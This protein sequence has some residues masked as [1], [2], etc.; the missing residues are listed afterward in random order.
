MSKHHPSDTIAKAKNGRW[1]GMSWSELEDVRRSLR[2]NKGIHTGLGFVGSS[3]EPTKKAF[4]FLGDQNGTVLEIRK[5]ST[6]Y[7]LRPRGRL[8]TSFN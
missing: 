8:I 3:H 2:T 7:D 4:L 6:G 1:L 5:N